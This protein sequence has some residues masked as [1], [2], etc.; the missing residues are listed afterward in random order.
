MA[1]I[2]LYFPGCALILSHLC[3]ER[4]PSNA[5]SGL[6]KITSPASKNV[7]VSTEHTGPG[8]KPPIQ[9]VIKAEDSGKLLPTTLPAMS[10]LDP[11]VLASLPPEILAEIRAV[12]DELPGHPTIAPRK[13]TVGSRSAPVSPAKR[14]SNRQASKQGVKL[15]TLFEKQFSGSVK[16]ALPLPL[17]SRSENGESSRLPSDNSEITALP[18]ASQVSHYSRQWF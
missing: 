10:D 13:A 8:W 18:P 15:E 9:T 6:P 1:C 7:T 17:D 11:S 12:Y 4:I 5:Q 2:F 16:R 3:A 14:V